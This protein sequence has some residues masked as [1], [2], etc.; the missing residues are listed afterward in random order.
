MKTYLLHLL[1]AIFIIILLAG[2]TSRE[3]ITIGISMGPVGER[4]E[5]D[6]TYLSQQL[7]SRGVKVI[8]KEAM[9]NQIEQNK[10]LMEFINKDKPDV[11]IIIPVNS[12][13]AGKAVDYV[14]NKNIKVIAYDRIIE[15]CDLD[16]YLSFDNV[17][18]GEIQAE[19]LSKIKPTGKYAVLGGDPDDNNSVLLR[20]GQMNILQPLIIKG[21]IEIVLD[22]NVEDWDT[23]NAYLITKEYL[24]QKKDLDAIVASN[25]EIAKG[26]IRALEEYGLAGT[27]LVSGQDAETDACRRIVQGTQ[28]MTVYKVIESLA[29]STT[30][31]AISLAQNHPIPNSLTTV[32][33]GRK[34]V[35]SI[36]L[37]S[38]IP[39]GEENIRMTVLADGFIDEKLV[40]GDN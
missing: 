26:A 13:T 28:T 29:T 27:V 20:I 14:K 9:E 31:I 40:F 25:D 15:N 11:L 37:S 22:Q 38:I 7:E 12:K 1:K 2:C 18:V 32:N 19:Y 16:C 17:R 24:E 8:I 30:N 21:D 33:N 4:W 10:Q 39:V 36:L 35:P 23:T 3:K 6:M 34:M 5:K